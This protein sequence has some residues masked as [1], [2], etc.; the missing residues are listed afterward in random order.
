MA[1]AVK[2]ECPRVR[3]GHRRGG[4][5]GELPEMGIEYAGVNEAG[6]TMAIAGRRR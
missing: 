3:D 6:T 4:C 1:I 5:R 2:A